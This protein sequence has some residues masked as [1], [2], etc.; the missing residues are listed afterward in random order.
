MKTYDLIFPN[1]GIKFETMSSVAFTLFG[2][3]V[4]WYG[5]IICTGILS[6][7]AV[8]MAVAKKNGQ[9]PEIYS[10]LLIYALVGAIIGARAYYVAFSWDDYKDDLMGILAFREGGLAIY[11]GVIGALMST[12]IY[13]KVKKMNFF[14]LTDT[15]IAGLAIG[16]AIGRWGNFMNMEAF[17]GYTNNFFAMAIRTAKAKYVP[18]SVL[19]KAV[20]IDGI[21]YIQVHPTFFYESMWC[22]MVLALLLFFYKHRKFDGEVFLLYFVGYGLGRVWI[23]GLRTDQLLIGRTGFAVSQILSAVLVLGAATIIIVKRIR[24]KK[25]SI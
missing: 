13:A 15:A 21:E 24:I 10:D 18:E 22:L 5:L 11:G 9:K 1:I 4:Y 6:G 16:Q 3:E 23:E 7:L 25:V 12:A 19:A 17:G 14:V 2:V 20:T 8:A